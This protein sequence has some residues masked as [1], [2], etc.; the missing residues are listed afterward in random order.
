MLCGGFF[1]PCVSNSNIS[2]SNISAIVCFVVTIFNDFISDICCI[3]SRIV[4]AR[5]FDLVFNF[6]IYLCAIARAAT[7]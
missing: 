3:V 7:I 1:A 4:L 5:P 6:L 2:S